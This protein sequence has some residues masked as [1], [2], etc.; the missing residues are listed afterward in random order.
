[1]AICKH[2]AIE[3]IRILLEKHYNETDNK[4]KIKHLG[5]LLKLCSKTLFT[6][7]GATHE[8]VEGTPM[9]SPLSSLTA[10]A[11]LQRL[12]ALAFDKY[13]PR[14]WGRSQH[15]LACDS[16][17]CDLPEHSNLVRLVPN[18]PN[19][20]L[21]QVTA[22]HILICQNSAA[23]AWEGEPLGRANVWPHAIYTES[24]RPI[25]QSPRRVP[26]QFQKQLEQAIKDRLDKQ[27]I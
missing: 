25:R 8:H 11:M 22:V 13:R 26:V 9:G 15:Q 18:S 14:L 19:L 3:T 5:D 12:E 20:S 1:M 4:I 24:S 10:E 23:F 6:F 16:G 21:G 27:V 17:G 7:N 2:L